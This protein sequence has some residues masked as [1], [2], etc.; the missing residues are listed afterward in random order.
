MVEHTCRRCGYTT[1]KK[2]NIKNH[3]QNI[4][5]CTPLYSDVPRETLLEELEITA[6]P[7]L[8]CSGCQKI[9]CNKYCVQRHKLG[10]AAHKQHLQVLELTTRMETMVEQEPAPPPEQEV[11]PPRRAYI[12]KKIPAALRAA[13]WNTHVGEE[14]GRVPCPVCKTNNIT[15]L[16]FNCGHVIAEANGGTASV[17]NLLPICGTCNSSMGSMNLHKFTRKYFPSPLVC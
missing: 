11:K 6:E 14:F 16:N 2:S 15:Q 12:K 17:E 7:D 10:C 3:L 8:C 5:E 13:V 9:L 1:G 4:K